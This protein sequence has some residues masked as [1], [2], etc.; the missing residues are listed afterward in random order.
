MSTLLPI[1][2]SPGRRDVLAGL[3]SAVLPVAA[4]PA[5]PVDALTLLERASGGRL[6]VHALD[7][8]SG[9]TLGHRAD[10]RFLMCSTFKLLLAAAVLARV[11]SGVERL[12]RRVPYTAAD[13]LGNAPVSRAHVAEGDLSV[14][15]LC[16][17]I[18]EVSDNA[19]AN[20]LLAASGGP[21]GVTLF[22][23]GIGDG[24]TRLDRIELALN[25]PDGEFDTTTPRAMVGSMRA[26]L[27]GR[28]LGPALRTML[29]D[30][31]SACTTGR[32][33]L[34]A[35][36]PSGWTAGDKTGTGDTQ[37]NDLAIIRPPGRAPLLVAAYYQDGPTSMEGREAVLRRV[38]SIVASWAA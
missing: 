25:D 6:G 31:M 32:H 33:R 1:F 9:R 36:L 18:V 19:A 20:L 26:I 22:A 17:A 37:T 28:A 23:R 14:G 29:E 11:A 8:G 5:D 38:G 2:R 24:I 13:L 16:R 21:A 35:G 15:T 4:R 30:W 27:L 7:T 10:E 3:S 34:R 12:D